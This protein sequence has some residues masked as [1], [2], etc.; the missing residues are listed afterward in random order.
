MLGVD[1]HHFEELIENHKLET[2]AN[3]DTDLSAE[4]WRTVVSGFK[5][6]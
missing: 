2:G 3:L 4:D 1:H 5:E 6:L